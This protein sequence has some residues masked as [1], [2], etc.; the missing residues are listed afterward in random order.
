M[1]TRMLI[2]RHNKKQ[3]SERRPSYHGIRYWSVM[4]Q[5]GGMGHK[6]RYTDGL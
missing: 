3:E 2:R 1:I 6:P 4:L 5:N